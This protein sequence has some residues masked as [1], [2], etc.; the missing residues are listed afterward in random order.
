[1]TL[2]DQKPKNQLWKHILAILVIVCGCQSVAA[3]SGDGGRVS[4]A[5]PA[6]LIEIVKA[7]VWPDN[8]VVTRMAAQRRLG[9]L[10]KETPNT[11]V[12]LLVRELETLKKRDKSTVHQR[13]A[14]IETLRD[15]GPGAEAASNVLIEILQDEQEP[16]DWVKMAARMAL[17]R[18]GVTDG[19]TALE[20]GSK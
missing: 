16:N 2:L 15:M 7:H 4:I 14:L 5:A 12:P 3:Q 8:D 19:R 9:Q 20:K 17:E 11:V 6:E 1:M 10:G 18:I 13:I